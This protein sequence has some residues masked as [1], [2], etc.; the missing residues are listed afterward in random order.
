M[1]MSKRGRYARKVGAALGVLAA[2]VC[3]PASSSVWAEE[4]TF[5]NNLSVPAIIVPDTDTPGVSVLRGGACGRVLSPWGPTSSDHPGR[6][7]QKTE[8]VWQAEC[9]TA[10]DAEV[11]V[12]WNDDLT[13]PLVLSS[14]LPIRIEVA[15]DTR[16]A[17]TMSG[18]WVERLSLDPEDRLADFGTR[19]VV[20]RFPTARVF[21]AGARLTVRRIL[22]SRALVYDGPVTA[23]IDGFGSLVHVVEWG[24][25]DSGDRVPPGVYR[26]T[27]ST[28]SARVTGVHATDAGVA[29]WTPSSSS[30]T[31]TVSSTPEKRGGSRDERRPGAS[32]AP[33]VSVVIIG[34]G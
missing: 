21:D 17:R 10:R 28:S 13:R 1:R 7:L 25:G 3:L 15:L 8:T 12:D 5:G 24:S 4:T 31:V 26:L 20:T 23:E 30:V 6:Y 27:F 32:R 29:E 18:F 16:L 33:D 14:Q 22:P 34:R 11:S 9:A 2:L 19:G